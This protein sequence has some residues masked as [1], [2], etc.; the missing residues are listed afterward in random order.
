MS[1]EEQIKIIKLYIKEREYQSKVFGEYRN[2]ALTF[3]SF[4]VF[5]SEYLDKAFSDYR[6]VW[7]K[8]MPP[9]LTNCD[10]YNKSGTAP[11]KSYEELIKIFALAGAV[12]E[13]F[14]DIDVE[15]WRKNPEEDSKKWIEKSG[16][17]GHIDDD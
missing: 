2:T 16:K 15:Q 11:V 6:D 12:L 7:E 14:T 13:T 9:W 3:P 10:E 1:S 4:L 17:G 5:L 8:D